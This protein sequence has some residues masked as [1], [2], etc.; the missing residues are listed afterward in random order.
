MKSFCS[1]M[2]KSNMKDG[3]FRKYLFSVSFCLGILYIFYYLIMLKYCVRNIF[4]LYFV[5]IL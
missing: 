5:D 1:N 4:Y 2:R 3:D